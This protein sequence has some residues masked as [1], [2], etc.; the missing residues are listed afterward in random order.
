[1]CSIILLPSFPWLQLESS[2]RLDDGHNIQQ[3][4]RIVGEEEKQKEKAA[5]STMTMTK[6]ASNTTTTTTKKN[7]KKKKKNTSHLSNTG[8]MVNLLP[9]FCK[10]TTIWLIRN[11]PSESN[12]K[13]IG[14]N[15]DVI[16]RYYHEIAP[17]RLE[18]QWENDYGCRSSSYYSTYVVA[19]GEAS[20][21][22]LYITVWL[23]YVLYR[24]STLP[25][26]LAS[27]VWLASLCWEWEI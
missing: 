24:R 4:N 23:Q 20:E 3:H 1:M 10:R 13:R 9:N 21:R 5:S 8:S 22:L 26:Y 27:S 25:T 16:T 15:K 14:K 12:S 19:L 18:G 11:Y 17:P 7:N 6:S 2:H